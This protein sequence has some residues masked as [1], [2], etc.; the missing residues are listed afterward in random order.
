M[1]EFKI[2]RLRFSWAGEWTVNEAYNRDEVVQYEG[3]AYVCL[4]PHTSAEFYAD[5]E[6]IVPKWNLMMTGQTWKGEWTPFTLFSLDNIVIFGGIVY[7]CNEQHVSQGVLDQDIEYWDIYIESKTWESQWQ[8]DYIYGIG[9]IV[10]YGGVVYD[11]IVSHQSA[12]TDAEGLE[13][14]LDKWQI[15]SYGVQFRGEYAPRQ[16][17]SSANRYKLNDIVRYDA[18]LYICIVGHVAPEDLDGSKWEL[19]LPGL[20]FENTWNSSTVYQQGD[21]VRYG[22][23]I[24]RNKLL[25]NN[26]I[27]P[28]AN[29]LDSTDAWE[30]I[31]RGYSL[32]ENWQTDVEYKVGSVVR[33]GGSLWTALIDNTDEVPTDAA[34]TVTYN[35]T[36]SSGTLLKVS[37][38]T[39]VTVGMTITGQGF[40]R[41]QNVVKVIDS[42]TLRI[43]EPPNKPI[44]NGAI[45]TFSGINF[46][47]KKLLRFRGGRNKVNYFYVDKFR[48]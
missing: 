19:W 33:Y 44:V 34:I 18:S 39:D 41:G 29:S 47:G 15:L 32:E 1:S 35:S 38:T 21:I 8:P 13:S 11:C 26:N 9:S 17:D 5:L 42:T 46:S 45:L 36:G 2:S 22:G 30:L 27:I 24:Y 6:N 3:K 43:N 48:T 20:R 4:E 16:P 12:E 23:Y 10:N 37:S 7:K 31:A 14:D 28:S 40:T 25:Q